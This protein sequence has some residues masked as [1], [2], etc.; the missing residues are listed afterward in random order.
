MRN[1]TVVVE[2]AALYEKEAWREPLTLLAPRYG[3]SNEGLADLCARSRIP[4]PAIGYRMR[5]ER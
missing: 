1:H 4:R 2:R 5:R 3:L